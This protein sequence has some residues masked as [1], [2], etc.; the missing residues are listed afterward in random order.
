MIHPFRNE[1]RNIYQNNNKML[2]AICE[3]NIKRD[4]WDKA[5]DFVCHLAMRLGWHEYP[6]QREDFLARMILHFIQGRYW[7][8]KNHSRGFFIP[9]EPKRHNSLILKAFFK[10]AIQNL[11]KECNVPV[12]LIIRTIILIESDYIRNQQRWK[13]K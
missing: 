10:V 13:E 1:V 5:F 9:E 12:H 7:T 11:A 2:D 8:N 6:V 3:E 4:A